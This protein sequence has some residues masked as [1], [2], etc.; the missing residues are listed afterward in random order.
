MTDDWKAKAT[1]ASYP[2]NR[3]RPTA[4][5]RI[6]AF[7]VEPPHPDVSVEIVEMVATSATTERVVIS[8]SQASHLR[9]SV[10]SARQSL[11]R[12]VSAMRA[13]LDTEPLFE[14]RLEGLLLRTL[15]GPRGAS[16]RAVNGRAAGVAVV[17]RRA[18]RY[19]RRA[20]SL[21]LAYDLVGH[22]VRVAPRQLDAHDNLPGSAKPIIDGIADGLGLKSD[23]DSR[24]EWVVS[25][26]I[27]PASVVIQLYR[28]EAP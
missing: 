13:V 11:E 3:A 18:A 22:V 25:Q 23:R 2:A 1:S 7:S 17:R 20:A 8:D 10:T 6:R 21:V 4:P 26:A 16:I 12:R 14:A 15:N 27:G 24:I 28:W 19:A 5:G 9:D